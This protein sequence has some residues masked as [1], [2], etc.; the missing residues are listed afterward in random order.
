MPAGCPGAPVRGWLLP[1]PPPHRP[2]VASAEG[3]PEPPQLH[4]PRAAQHPGVATEPCFLLLRWCPPGDRAYEA[5]G[6]KVV[7]HASPKG[8]QWLKGQQLDLQQTAELSSSPIGGPRGQAESSVSP[9]LLPAALGF[10]KSSFLS[11]LFFPCTLPLCGLMGKN[12]GQP[13]HPF[14]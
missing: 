8:A 3:Y 13:L 9:L 11:F 5:K 2:L 1:L 4:H 7:S 12:P 10:S 6:A 14:D